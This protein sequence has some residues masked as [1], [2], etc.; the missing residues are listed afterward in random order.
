[1]II[2]PRLP[3]WPQRL[4]AWVA[5]SAAMPFDWGTHDCGL[6]AGSAA[7]AQI[8][9][10]FAADFRGKYTTYQGGLKLLRKAGFKDHAELAASIFPEFPPAFAQ[11]GD[12][13]AVDFGDA[14]LTLMVVAGHRLIGP[15]PDMAGS[16]PLT[17]ACRAFAVGRQP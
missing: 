2:H 3:D 6:N 10:D 8:G 11:I 5:K 13:A 15:M 9:I 17:Q 14:G 16:L 12:L 4:D 1:M 7:E